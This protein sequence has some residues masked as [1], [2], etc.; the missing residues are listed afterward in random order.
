MSSD[1]KKKSRQNSTQ[2]YHP[3]INHQAGHHPGMPYPG[4]ELA[5]AYIPIQKL[6]RVYSPAQALEAGTLFP[7]LYR[8]YP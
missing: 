4:M 3:D 7:E 1:E 5:R 2:A 6:G 8:P